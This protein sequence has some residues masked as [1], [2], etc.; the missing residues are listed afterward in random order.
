MAINV[1]PE[2][3]KTLFDEIY[4]KTDARSVCDNEIS[5]REVDLI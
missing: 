5:S 3:W 1:D 4:L 2:W